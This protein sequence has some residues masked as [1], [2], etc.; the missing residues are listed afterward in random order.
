VGT[1]G[2]ILN[3]TDGI[4]WSNYSPGTVNTLY[5]IAYG[6]STYV[7]VGGSGVILTS[8]DGSSWTS[9][10]SGTINTLYGITFGNNQF[11]VVGGSGT[12]LTSSTGISW[13]ARTSAVT[14]ALRGAAYGSGSSIFVIVGDYGEILT[15]SSGIAWTSQNSGTGNHLHAVTPGSAK[16]AAVGEDTIIY[17]TCNPLTPA[18]TLTSPNGGEAWSVGVSHDI[19]WTSFGTVGNVKIDYSVNNGTNWIEIIASTVNDGAY[20]WT[21]PDNPSANCRV[22]ISESG[23]S[24]VDTSDA[25]FS[26]ITVPEPGLRVLSPNGGETF[27][28]GDIHTITWTSTGSVG[29]VRLEYSINSGASWTV[30]TSS[31]VN[32]GSF[33][34]TVPG[35]SFTSD[36]CLVRISEADEDRKPTDTSDAEFTIISPEIDSLT[37]VSPNG[38]EVLTAGSNHDIT[39]TSTGTVGNIKIEYSTNSGVSWMFYKQRRFLDGH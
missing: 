23:G 11:V 8:T 3:S 21:I 24:P 27:N 2:T 6:N 31:T 33:D 18:V 30:I 1:N 38:R 32:D 4:S 12:I 16:F 26:I 29:N 34:W 10:V 5:A 28:A 15:G 14:T 20:A 37:L 22:R 17:T 35:I 9:R 25:V 7:A 13:T 19:T 39:W 36:H